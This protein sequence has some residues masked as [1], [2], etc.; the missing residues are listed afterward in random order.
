MGERVEMP[1]VPAWV[2]ALPFLFARDKGDRDVIVNSALASAAAAMAADLDRRNS[3]SRICFLLA[4]LASQ[5]GRRTGEHFGWIPVNRTQL[6]RAAQIN[7]TKVKRVL[8]FLLLAGVVELGDEGIRIADCERL[9]KLGCYDRS[10][11]PVPLA[12]VDEQAPQTSAPE[13]AEMPA[14]TAAGDQASFV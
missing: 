10:W 2:A 7:L 8:G 9:C 1:A 13:Q 12:D 5:Y 11:L 6:A 4:E 14:L 3:R